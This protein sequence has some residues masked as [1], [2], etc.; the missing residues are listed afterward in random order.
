MNELYVRNRELLQL[1]GI[2]I[3]KLG[4]S[5]QV[6]MEDYMAVQGKEFFSTRDENG[7]GE[8]KIVDSQMGH[9]Q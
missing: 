3:H 6:T 1:L 7:V 8:L 5:M 2:A 4:G 9:A